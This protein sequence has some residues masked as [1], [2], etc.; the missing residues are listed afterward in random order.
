[1]SVQRCATGSPAR[2][3]TPSRPASP[4]EG[5]GGA[6]RIPCG[7]VDVAEQGAGPVGIA[8]QD[9]DLVAALE[10]SRDEPRTD[11]PRGAGDGDLHARTLRGGAPCETIPSRRYSYRHAR[12]SPAQPRDPLG[13]GRHGFPAVHGRLHEARSVGR[14]DRRLRTVLLAARADP[15]GPRDRLRLRRVVRG[16][17]GADRRDG[18]LGLRGERHRAQ[19]RVHRADH[20]RCGRPQR[21]RC[22]RRDPAGD[23]R[24]RG[25]PRTAAR[26]RRGRGPPRGAPRPDARRRG[27]R[28]RRLQ[29]RPALPLPQQARARARSGGRLD[30]RFEAEVE[31]MPDG[32]RGRLDS[33]LRPRLR[34]EP[35]GAGR[36]RRGV[37]AARA[38]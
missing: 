5:S 24:E 29:G 2:C 9:R 1:M 6:G 20:R 12:R 16:R 11:E 34:H 36:A 32:G 30:G 4:T 33:R 26:R 35:H 3:T 25:D 15:Q 31:P 17:H 7:G 14:G 27:R 28:G 18:H 38:C 23:P 19:V 8:G 21:R 10:Q 22:V 13:G 37:L